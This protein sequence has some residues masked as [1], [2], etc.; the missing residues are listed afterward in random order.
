MKFAAYT[1][2]MI[3]A[4]ADTEEAARAKAIFETGDPTLEF[5][6][7][8]I[9]IDYADALADGGFNGELASFDVIDGRVVCATWHTH[10][11]VE[12]EHYGDLLTAWSDA[13]PLSNE[14]F[15]D[16]DCT[17]ILRGWRERAF[18]FLGKL[19]QDAGVVLYREPGTWYLYPP[20][21]PIEEVVSGRAHALLEGAERY[22]PDLP[23]YA[24]AWVQ[25]QKR[26]GKEAA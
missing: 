6:V 13:D 9:D 22:G 26:K 11:A 12:G 19:A 24:E 15:V 2:E 21:T 18:E 17:L 23:D 10:I 5:R 3:I 25:M 20:R 4:V 16:A 1:D 8:P 7:S 14:W